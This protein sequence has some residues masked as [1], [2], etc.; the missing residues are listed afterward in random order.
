M[1]EY[2][3][4]N[5]LFFLLF[6]AMIL[7][8]VV[9]F[10]PKDGYELFGIKISFMTWE[11][12]LNPVTQ[13]NKDLKFLD[14]VNINDNQDQEFLKTAQTDSNSLGLPTKD[15]VL[16]VN[17][18][19]KLHMNEESKS[20]LFA[21]FSELSIASK[22]KGKINICHYGD[23]Q[24]EGDRMTSF[25]RQRLQTQFGGAGPGL[26]PA[27]NVYSTISF[28]HNY[29]PNFNRKMIF[30]KEKL[31]SNKYGL[32]LSA[33][34]FDIDSSKS[35]KGIPT[36][37]WIELSPSNVAYSRCKAY[38]NLSVFY[39]SCNAH[40]AIEVY[41]KGDLIVT[42]TLNSDGLPHVFNWRFST[43]PEKLKIIFKS[44]SSP[45]INAV[46]IEGD[47]GVQMS[48]I[49]MRG[50]SGTSFGAVDYRSMSF[51]HEELNTKLI[52]LQFGGNSVPFFKDSSSVRGYAY[53]FRK[54]IE[55]L[56]R[57]AKDAAIIVIGPSD[58][59]QYKE[60]IYSTYEYLPYCVQQMKIQSLKAGASY[61]DLY[62]AMGGK[63]S[64]FAWVNNGL[65]GKDY[66]HFSHHGA[67]KASQLFYNALISAYKQWEQSRIPEKKK[68]DEL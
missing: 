4:I 67:N 36:Q 10:T 45:I 46:S 58:M 31:S 64:M 44:T 34:V 19:T 24:I 5:V 35:L 41:D 50:S 29:S 11:N 23:S 3:P 26:I 6:T 37:A 51:M 48:N 21:F 27:I 18:K 30:G 1:K 54:Q 68:I 22:K 17:S 33:A 13:E 40:C 8:P 49:A 39:N 9:Y 14:D 62:D 2:R 28:R 42:D 20:N 16:A 61:W 66:V 57:C 47:V 52:I 32:M 38:N 15:T 25:I 7:L 59:A 43:T 55:Y 12:L 60:G 53:R 65:A 56:Q 63:N